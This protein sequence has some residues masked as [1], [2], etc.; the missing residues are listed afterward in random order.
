MKMGSLRRLAVCLV[1]APA[2]ACFCQE[3]PQEL[4]GVAASQFC[5]PVQDTGS[6]DKRFAIAIG[7]KSP[8]PVD[9]TKYKEEGGTYALDPEGNN[10][11]LANF[12]VDV[13]KDRAIALLRGKHFGTRKTYNH[14]SCQV[15]WSEKGGYLVEMQSWKWHTASGMLYRLDADGAVS[16]RL[17]LLALATGELAKRMQANHKVDAKG[18]DAKYASSLSEPAVDDTGRVTVHATAEV[19][20]SADDPSLSVLITFTAKPDGKGGLEAAELVVKE[21]AE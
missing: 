15:A 18:Y 21:E 7:F 11:L 9:W 13:K 6:P 12:L 8:A 19:P 20:K 10:P 5:K 2:A 14:E 16:S 3:L 17:D 1:M 4:K